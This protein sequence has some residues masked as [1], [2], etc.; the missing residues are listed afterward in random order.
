MKK[1]QNEDEFYVI[2]YGRSKNEDDLQSESG[3]ML[4]AV[5][6]DSFDSFDNNTTN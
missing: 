5:Q 2:I 1:L 4:T 6:M 3:E